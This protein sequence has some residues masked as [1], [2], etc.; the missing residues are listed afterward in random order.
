MKVVTEVPENYQERVK[1]GSQLKISIPDAGYQIVDAVIISNRSKY[2]QHNKSIFYG[3]KNSIIA[4]FT[5]KPGGT[6]TYKR[7][8]CTK[9]NYNSV[10]LVQ[11]DESGKYVY[12]IA[13]EGEVMKARKKTVNVGEVYSG[14]I[15]VKAG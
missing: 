15:E 2:C 13:K 6:C 4:G 5:I 7:L 8:S 11:S 3:S 9:R 10:N 1:K 14:M 12:V